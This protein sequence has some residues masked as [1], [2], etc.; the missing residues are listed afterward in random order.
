MET[1]VPETL[2]RAIQTTGA[3]PLTSM[4]AVMQDAKDDSQLHEA[5]EE[6]VRSAVRERLRRDPDYDAARFPNAEDY[7]QKKKW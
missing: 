7:F 4:D 3:Q 5:C 6:Q 2:R 1:Y